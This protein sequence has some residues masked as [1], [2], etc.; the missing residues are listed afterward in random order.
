MESGLYQGWYFESLLMLE[1]LMPIEY[2]TQYCLRLTLPQPTHLGFLG[3]AQ[4]SAHCTNAAFINA[5]NLSS[6]AD[7]VRNQQYYIARDE[8]N[9]TFLLILADY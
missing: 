5:A 9:E 6:T 4:R 2:A 1:L 8:V 7:E 3:Q